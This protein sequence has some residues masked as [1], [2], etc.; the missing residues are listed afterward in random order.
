MALPDSKTSK[1]TEPGGAGRA[2]E[3]PPGLSPCCWKLLQQ[4]GNF[5]IS[6]RTCDQSCEHEHH[7]VEQEQPGVHCVAA[8]TKPKDRKTMKEESEIG[9]YIADLTAEEMD[10]D[11]VT[12]E[13][14]RYKSS[15][16]IDWEEAY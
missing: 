1:A 15:D 3:L 10:A 12:V 16:G 13:P 14:D 5:I 8:A 2:G 7:K 9:I 6:E 4:D 11:V